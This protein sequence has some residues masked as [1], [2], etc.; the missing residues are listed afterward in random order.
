MALSCLFKQCPLAKLPQWRR[1]FRDNWEAKVSG[2]GLGET[3][4]GRESRNR[5]LSECARRR[6]VG[7]VL[8]E[9]ERERA[10]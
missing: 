5:E 7:L 1:S 3:E 6:I 4:S 9:S 10:E 2:F 8:P